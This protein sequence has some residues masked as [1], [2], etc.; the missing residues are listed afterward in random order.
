[1]EIIEVNIKEKKKREPCYLA[2]GFFDGFHKGHELLLQEI[3]KGKGAKKAL[4][5]FTR[6]FKSS[7]KKEKEELLLTK[8]ETVE[9]CEKEG[10]DILYVLPF[11]EET[12]KASVNDFL[13]FL[14]SLNPREIVVGE[15]FTFAY[16]AEGNVKT[17]EKLQ[18]DGIEV[19]ALPLLSLHGEKVASRS[20]KEHLHNKQVA[21]AK[22]E[23]G[24]PFF[25][26]G[27]VLHGY[28]NG[29]KLGFPTAN[30]LLPQGKVRLPDGV[31]YTRTLVDGKLYSSMTNIGS[32]P[33]ID[34]L[35]IDIAETN[36][37]GLKEDLYGKTIRV[38]FLDYLR[39]Q[40]KFSSLEEL[41]SQLAKD[42]IEC[43]KKEGSTK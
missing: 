6:S 23:L 31:Y 12:W 40:K 13:S 29:Q 34:E 27:K 15:D 37:F 8:E 30:L 10:I 22:E 24:Y 36:I 35:P 11:N 32:H 17:L 33:T 16:K 20:I 14:K 3:E 2:I 41:R 43:L 42:K 5:T 39:D 18:E 26:T 19:K 1:M 25:Y 28:Q 4:L 7:L 38:Y 9:Y 21:L